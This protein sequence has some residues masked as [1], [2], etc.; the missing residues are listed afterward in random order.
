[1]RIGVVGDIHGKFL[2]LKNALN[3]M[4]V[5]DEL[6]F[7]GDGIKEIN[8]LRLENGVILRGVCGNC[9]LSGGYSELELFRLDGFKVLLTHGH[10]YGVKSGMTRIE[11]AAAAEEARLVV[12]GHTHLPF[13][14]E[15]RGI[16]F[17]NPGTLCRERAYQVV[18]Y[19]IIEVDGQGLRLYHNEL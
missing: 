19:G 11:M 2:E 1:M 8:R 16:R 13:N 4:G 3:R 10:R 9:D 17:F 18:T 6:W 15:W 14:D 12:F 5:I 7:T